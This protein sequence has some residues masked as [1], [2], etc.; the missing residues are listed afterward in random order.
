M[1]RFTNACVRYV[2]RLMPDP[3]LL[4]VLLTAVAV[5]AVFAAVPNASPGGL[6]DAWFSGVWGANNIFA[7]ALQMI[8]ILVAGY[9]LAEA[10]VVQRGLDR[11][12]AIPKSQLQ[13]A[14]V[15]FFAAAIA[16][17]LNWGLGLVVGA[18]VARR[19]ALRMPDIHFGYLVAAGYAGFIVW[20]SGFSSSIALANTD[21]NSS[22]NVIN[23]LTGRSLT[24]IDAI[25]QPASWVPVL[26][27]LAVVPLLLRAML[28]STVL[29]P[30]RALFEQDEADRAERRGDHGRAEDEAG[31]DGSD[32]G[33]GGKGTMPP[34][35]DGGAAGTVETTRRVSAATA[36]VEKPT[37]AQRLENMWLI[38]VLLAAAGLAYFVRSGFTL[39][40][41]SMVMLF[42]VL[43][44]LLHW[45]PARF[46][47]AFTN[48]AKTA[49][50]L[51]LQYPLYGGVIALLSY[52]P[53]AD[54]HSLAVVISDGISSAAN[55]TTLPFFHFLAS[56]VITLF[57]PS[58]GG[59]WAVQGPVAVQSAID[60]NQTSAGELGKLSMAV[61]AGEQVANMIQPF[62][63][64][65]VLAI[66]KLSVRDVMGFTVVLFLVGLVVFGLGFLLIPAVG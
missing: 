12:A 17:L 25:G 28:P 4:A 58:G 19:I 15:C 44:L 60:L 57:V 3:F 14:L 9:T 24:L 36:V 34:T 53:S 54:A 5:I 62:W 7:F 48:A 13:A 51:V 30:D 41:T 11:I 37:P 32:D 45:T 33:A 2:E 49:G 21:P 56:N 38:N 63:L 31:T 29:R 42:T 16:S 59:H 66:A 65:P 20:A 61:A 18:L 52:A 27:M 22:L 43:G 47:A 35:G 40:I 26:V 64:L 6:L 23:T 50:P 10:P 46:I 8:I 39:D 1:K 55:A